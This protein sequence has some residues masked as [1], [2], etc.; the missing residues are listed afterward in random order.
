MKKELNLKLLATFA[1]PN[2]QNQTFLMTEDLFKIAKSLFNLP[3]GYVF[4][5]LLFIRQIDIHNNYAKIEIYG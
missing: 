4:D 3:E 5:N 2:S 1:I